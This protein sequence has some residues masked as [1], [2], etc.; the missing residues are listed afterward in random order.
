VKLDAAAG[1]ATQIAMM[2]TTIA[3]LP[4]LGIAL[5]GT[6]LV[7]Q[8]IGAGDRDWAMKV[9]TRVTVFAAAYMG[10]MGILLAL[11]GPWLM[12]L[13]IAA[14]DAQSAAVVALGVKIL[15]FAAVYQFFDGLNLGS[16]FCLRGAGDALVP[17]ALVLG[18]AWLLFVPLAHMLI[19]ASGQ[20]W[21]DVLPQ[22]GWGALGG[23]AALVLY[24]LLLGSMLFVRWRSGAWR[25]LRI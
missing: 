10:G 21:V 3:Y 1:A 6:T 18:L 22:L 23:W 19:F 16:G 11:C 4:G 7:G 24:V 8:S 12:P 2:L 13:F 25:R 20:G 17:A 5:A 14:H 9:G 15:W